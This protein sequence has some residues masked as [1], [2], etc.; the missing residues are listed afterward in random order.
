MV[1]EFTTLHL[2]INAGNLPSFVM[3]FQ[4]LCISHRSSDLVWISFYC[5]R[6]KYVYWIRFALENNVGQQVVLWQKWKVRRLWL[7]WE[8]LSNL[9][10]ELGSVD[11]WTNE[12]LD[13][14]I[15]CDSIEYSLNL[16]NPVK[17]VMGLFD[18]SGKWPITFEE[19]RSELKK[20]WCPCQASAIK[21]EIPCHHIKYEIPCHHIISYHM[22]A[23]M[24]WH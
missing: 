1:L 19:T 17:I 23:V 21:Y 16:N 15:C 12:I 13:C 4:E 8:L 2:F 20:M 10:F 6:W 3:R 11:N 5:E 18:G 9:S 24:G 7:R 14:A 22:S